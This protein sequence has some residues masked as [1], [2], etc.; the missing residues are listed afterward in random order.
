[1]QHFPPIP[2]ID[3]HVTAT[4]ISEGW[5]YGHDNY[6]FLIYAPPLSILWKR[7]KWRFSIMLCFW[8]WYALL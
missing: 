8:I 7:L 4:G 5:Q 6:C 2:C 1:L 3:I